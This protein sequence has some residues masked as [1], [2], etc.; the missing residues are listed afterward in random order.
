MFNLGEFSMKKTLVAIAALAAVS[1]FA[2][3]SVTINGGMRIGYGSNAAG[4]KGLQTTQGSG[5]T[6][7]VVV[8]EDLGG[9]LAAEGAVQF[10]YDLTN[11][12]LNSGKAT[13]PVV[14]G[15]AL[16]TLANPGAGAAATAGNENTRLLHTTRLGLKGG[17]GQAQFGRIGLDQHWGYTSFGSTA[18]GVVLNPATALGATEDNQIR[19]ISP[20]FAGFQAHL[21]ASTKNNNGGTFN[22]GAFNGSQVYLNYANGP[23]AALFVSEKLNNG[24]KGNQFGASY[25]FG[26]AK[27]NLIAGSVKSAASVK[28]ANGLALTGTIPFGAATIK[29]GFKNDKLAANN[30]TN[31]LG[32]DYAL[33]KRTVAEVNTWKAKADTKRSFWVGMKHSF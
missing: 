27:V 6:I 12:V 2:Q 11:G 17:F 19:Y 10:R 5:N 7:N 33:S 25:N 16:G 24:S 32:L 4:A 26:V 30:D 23:L 1:A 14:A 8:V 28:T 31:A 21:A 18:P 15:G 13:A 3:S 20:N 9:G 29:L 22:E